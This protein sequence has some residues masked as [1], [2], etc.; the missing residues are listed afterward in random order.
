MRTLVA[1]QGSD[2]TPITS[3]IG[4]EQPTLQSF[5]VDHGEVRFDEHIEGRNWYGDGTV[6]RGAARR[7]KELQSVLPQGHGNLA[8]SPEGVAFVQAN[9]RGRSLQEPQSQL[10]RSL[11][12]PEAV[13]RGEQFKIHVRGNL[14]SSSVG[15]FEASTGL[16]GQVT[17]LSTTLANETLS[18]VWAFENEGLY[19]ITLDGGGLSQ[20]RTNVLV[21]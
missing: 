17:G 12:V 15:Y 11:H 1:E 14:Q 2:A 5:A 13:E 10:V 21:T 16:A 9:L 7:T 8:S 20:A 3:L 18:T 19:T 6:Y 4:T